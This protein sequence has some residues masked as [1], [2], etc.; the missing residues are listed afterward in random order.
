[1]MVL[2]LGVAAYAIFH[3]V[4]G[5]VHLPSNVVENG[6]FSPLGLEIHIAASGVALAIGPLQFLRSVREGLPQLHR[7]MGRTYVTACL[8]GGAAGAAIAMY[9]TAGMVAGAGFLSLAVLWLAFTGS[10]FFSARARDFARHERFMVRSFALTFAA[11]TLRIY[12]PVGLS[13]NPS[14][15]VLPYT[16]IAWA[17]WVPNLL[18]AEAWLAWRSPRPVARARAMA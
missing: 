16:I 15:F 14:D 8:I 7:W 12:L 18:I 5:F 2:S 10:A 1:M 3:V 11:V 9:S 13:L 17:C 6:F 4:T